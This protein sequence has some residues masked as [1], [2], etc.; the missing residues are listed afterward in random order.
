MLENWK[1]RD[2]KGIASTA[3]LT[4]LSQPSDCFPQISVYKV[5][6]KTRLN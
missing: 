3:L 5:S 1:V 6:V 2:H 4:D